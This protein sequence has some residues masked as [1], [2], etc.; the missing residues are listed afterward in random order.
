[1]IKKYLISYGILLS[2]I[3][4]LTAI[5]STI[6]YFMILPINVFKIIIP[7]ISLFI[8]SI[9][10]GRGIKEKG[11]IQ[12]LKFSSI[13]LIFVTIIK[14]IFHTGINLKIMIMYLLFVFSSVVGSMIGINLKKTE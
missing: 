12:G 7:I 11:Y 10:L 14:I 9:I 1:M 6:N 13:Y 5:L 2:L 8:S 3:I 4:I